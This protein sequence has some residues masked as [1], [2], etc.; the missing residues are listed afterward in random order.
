MSKEDT[1]KTTGFITE[2]LP[3]AKFRVKLD[4]NEHVLLAH[5]SGKMRKMNINVVLDD[6]V[7][8]EISTYDLTKCRITYRN[9]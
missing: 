4:M 8:V 6:N 7:E 9:K 3:N 1:I 5:L 2:C